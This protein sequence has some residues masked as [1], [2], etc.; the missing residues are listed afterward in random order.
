MMSP[1]SLLAHL[2]TL[3]THPLAD[4]VDLARVGAYRGYREV[5]ATLAELAASPGASARS[6][7]SSVR[8]VP[9]FALELGAADAPVAT[10]I[11]AGLHPLEWIGVETA[12]ALLARLCARP[13]AD[14]RIVAIPLVNVDGFQTVEAD[15]RAGRRRFRRGNARGVDLNRNFPT[16]FRPAAPHGLRAALGGWNHGGPSALSEPECAAVVATLDTVSTRSRIDH[17]LSLH[18]IGRMILTP[19]GGRLR[20]PEAAPRLA[21]AAES[22]RARLPGYRAVQS[23]WWVPGLRGH[24]M[25]LDHLYA[26]YDATALLVECTG[27]GAT[28]REPRSLVHPFRWFN[29]PDP[30]RHAAELAGALE[31]FVRGQ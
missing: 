27:G 19:W 20:R 6:I 17:A 25:E 2:G 14:R 8:E 15:L 22:V 31:P 30:A 4:D 16:H 11:I 18:S 1:V 7:G 13:P 29:P 5:I 3:P 9:L 12:L 26:A 10:A 24:G 21:A 28:L 23:S